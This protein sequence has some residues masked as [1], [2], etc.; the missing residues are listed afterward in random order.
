MGTVPSKTR[1]N[2]IY[3]YI[4]YIV[5]ST[6]YVKTGTVPWHLWPIFLLHLEA[7]NSG[8]YQ[9]FIFK[10]MKICD[11]MKSTRLVNMSLSVKIN[12]INL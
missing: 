11:C 12:L 6:D 9:Q 2:L 7:L 3:W 10:I 8:N 4:H 1:N 5:L